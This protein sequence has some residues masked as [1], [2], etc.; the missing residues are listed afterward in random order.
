M[1]SLLPL[2]ARRRRARWRRALMVAGALALAG[3]C[4]PAAAEVRGLVALQNGEICPFMRPVLTPPPGWTEDGVRC[5]QPLTVLVPKGTTI[6]K[7]PA[8]IYGR[9]TANQEKLSVETFIQNSQERWKQSVR[10][11][12]ITALGEVRRANGKAAFK[13][14]RYD[15]PSRPKQPVEFGAFT[16]DT[17]DK[18]NEYRVMV[19]LTATSEAALRKAESGYRAMLGAY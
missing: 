14:F 3:A 1:T 7:G 11:A 2:S 10:D 18:G 16:L 9:A 4:H 13:L 8:A 12:R 5:D 15:N 6:G 19:M 17:D